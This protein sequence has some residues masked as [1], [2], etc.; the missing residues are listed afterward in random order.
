[1][2]TAFTGSGC[3]AAGVTEPEKPSSID[4]GAARPDAFSELVRAERQPSQKPD[5]V[6]SAARVAVDSS[7]C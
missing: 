2:P 5:P 6:G 1:M 7:Q 4:I 3:E